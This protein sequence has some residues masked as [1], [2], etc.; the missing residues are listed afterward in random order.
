MNKILC[1]FV[2]YPKYHN[3]ISRSSL[4]IT[5]DIK[6][7]DTV[8][9]YECPIY[10]TYLPKICLKF[11]QLDICSNEMTLTIGINKLLHNLSTN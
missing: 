4:S 9:S 10:F 5:V 7:N 6:T 1:I 3:H 11:S 8:W 2:T